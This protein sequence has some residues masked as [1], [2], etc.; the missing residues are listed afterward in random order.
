MFLPRTVNQSNLPPQGTTL[1]H[2]KSISEMMA[3]IGLNKKFEVTVSS[4]R[5]YP[6]STWFKP[7]HHIFTV[8]IPL[9][10]ISVCGVYGFVVKTC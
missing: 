1:I 5:S 7:Y 4:S 8:V 2:R 6:H 3:L 9:E 10:M